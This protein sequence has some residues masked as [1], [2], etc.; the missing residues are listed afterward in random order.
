[1]STLQKK[2]MLILLV[3]LPFTLSAQ[4]PVAETDSAKE[5]QPVKPIRVGLI[6]CDTHGMWF[7][8]Q[9]Q[10][11]D[12]LLFS[13]PVPMDQPSKYSWMRGGNHYYF[14]TYY[15]NP[16]H[17]TAPFVDG[18]EIVKVWDKDRD[19]AEL[20][21]KIFNSSP[22]VCES[23]EQVSDDVDLVFIADCNGDGHDHLKLATPGLKKGI[24]TFVDKPFAHRMADVV[25]L[26]KLAEEND[27]PI[28]SLSIIQTLPETR[29]FANR[30]DEL[31]EVHF[32]TIQGGGTS[33]AGLIH[34]IC[35]AIAIYGSNV[36]SVRVVKS[37]SHTSIHLDWGSQ[38]N[39]P[40]KGVMINCDIGRTWH[41]SMH[42]SAYGPGGRGAIHNQGAGSWEYPQGSAEILR[43]IKKMVETGKTQGP[44]N[45]MIEAVA[46]ADAAEAAMKAGETQPFEIVQPVPN[47]NL[48]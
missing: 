6:G 22:E 11:H 4:I 44:V 29:E 9:M 40:Q 39:R 35:Y 16:T 48:K 43:L 47:L 32:G 45:Q 1:M 19:A 8:P 46:I 27:A 26:L 37:P 17:M 24:P 23:F 15:G 10:K 2:M 21:A 38:P 33:R 20:A 25:A 42:M 36:E 28:M 30:L 3:L 7:G 41:G 18:F 5:T 34:T 12:S 14:Y 31:E 13:L